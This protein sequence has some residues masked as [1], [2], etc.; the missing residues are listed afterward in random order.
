MRGMHSKNTKNSSDTAYII[1]RVTEGEE[2]VEIREYPYK[3]RGKC[4][5]VK[6][7]KL[8]LFLES[9]ASIRDSKRI[10]P[11]LAQ[12]SLQCAYWVL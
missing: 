12:Q 5:A 1:Q 9:T 3:V 10:F 4:A 6:R 8:R 11:E 2:S 7:F